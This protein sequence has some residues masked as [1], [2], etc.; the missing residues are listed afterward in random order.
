MLIIR[1]LHWTCAA[2]ADNFFDG[3]EGS[4][5]AVQIHRNIER[6]DLRVVGHRAPALE[7]CSARAHFQLDTQLRDFPWKVRDLPSLRIHLNDRLVT[8]IRRVD[9]LSV[10]SIELPQDSELAHFEK[11]LPSADIDEDTFEHFIHVLRL[12]RQ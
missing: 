1:A 5:L 3:A 6:T 2:L 8:E 12:S 9:E 10:R 7:S 4:L 11:R